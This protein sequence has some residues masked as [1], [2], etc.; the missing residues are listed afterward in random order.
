MISRPIIKG[1]FM[2]KLPKKA[3]IYVLLIITMG[4]S[5]IGY[6]FLTKVSVDIPAAI[7]FIILG[8]ITESL[9][10]TLKRDSV[11]SVAFAVNIATIMYFPIQYAVI[12]G[13]VSAILPI[14]KYNGK[15]SHIF[16][17][18]LYKTLFNGSS[19][20]III[21]LAGLVYHFIGNHFSIPEFFSFSVFGIGGLI[22]MYIIADIILFSV[23]FA[24]LQKENF[25]KIATEQSWTI[26]NYILLSPLGVAIAVM[27][28]WQG[29]FPVVLFFGPLLL[30]RYSFKL[31]LET[32]D[33]LQGTIQALS[34]AMDAKDHYTNGHSYRVSEVAV[35][36][37]K[38]MQLSDR[39]IERLK[40]AAVLHDIGK[41]GVEDM[42]LNK[43]TKLEAG[44]FSKIM[45][46][47]E[48]GAKIL[49]QVHNL[50][51]ISEIVRYHHVHYNGEGYPII[52]EGYKVPIES[53][54]L[55]VS[56]AYDAMTSDRPYRDALSDLEAFHRLTEGA[57]SQFHPEVIEA[58]MV[59]F[60]G[61]RELELDAG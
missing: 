19:R 22:I 44:E 37:G 58:F 38:I 24:F 34:N 11:I 9:P 52:P 2:S 16:N 17:H 59:Y 54:I 29:A 36:I 35:H 48:I 6:C 42:I 13:F 27:Y 14:R 45:E 3:M 33:A 7:V 60:S 23:L 46:H 39:S 15:I 32:K 1:A 43:T 51:E 40:S 28:V 12:I 53:Y 50:K 4:I 55:S 31:Y 25:I 61:Q 5:L 18:E 8:I 41:I 21:F 57:G 47:P 10:I 26:M 30:A 49:A 56:D 20:A